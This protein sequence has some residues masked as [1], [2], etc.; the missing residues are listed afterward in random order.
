MGLWL[1]LVLRGGKW[2]VRLT[3]LWVE[4]ET[5]LLGGAFAG[6]RWEG[7]EIVMLLLRCDVGFLAESFFGEGCCGTDGSPGSGLDGLSCAGDG[8][9]GRGV[10]PINE[11]DDDEAELDECV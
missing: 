5:D 7:L 3:F 1:K 6:G 4:D 8:L 10:G 9:C 11:S 2:G